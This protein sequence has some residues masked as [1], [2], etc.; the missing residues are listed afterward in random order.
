MTL[1][2][3]RLLILLVITVIGVVAGRL[4]MR[5][6]L[7]LMLAARCLEGTFYEYHS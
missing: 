2:K 3:K 7:N 1:T 5:A 6:F 4:A